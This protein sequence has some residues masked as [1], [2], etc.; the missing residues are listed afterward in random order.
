MEEG[1]SSFRNINK[2]KIV[3][4]MITR[5]IRSDAYGSVNYEHLQLNQTINSDLGYHCLYE[6]EVKII[7]IY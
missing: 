2:I 6:I 3:T 4:R 1:R 7:R 5:C